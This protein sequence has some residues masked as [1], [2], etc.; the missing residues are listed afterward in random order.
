MSNKW[1]D[2]FN[3]EIL[4]DYVLINV[5]KIKFNKE[6]QRGI[7]PQ[8][9]KRVISSIK[10]YGY[11]PQEVITLNEKFEAIDG[12]HRVTAA[13]HCKLSSVP[14]SIIKFETKIDESKFFSQKNDWNNKL[15]PI[16]AW[17]AKYIAKH[18]TA[19]TVYRLEEDDNSL[20]FNYIAIKTKNTKT[21]F[22]VSDAVNIIST[23]ALD[24]LI[25]WKQAEDNKILNKIRNTEY[26]KIL[27]DTNN[28]L[29]IFYD[30]FGKRLDNP[31]AYRSKCISAFL[32]FY[33]KLK[34][35]D[36]LTT[37]KKIRDL[38]NKMKNFHIGDAY[39][40]TDHVGM[41]V[42]LIN[43]FNYK[44]SFKNQLRVE[45]ILPTYSWR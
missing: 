15:K 16:D 7:E 28:F 30:I 19:L 3:V 10:K 21:K 26:S 14:C 25:T 9:L 12:N 13:K 34:T 31:S 2:D 40:K 32:S 5:D 45:T 8:R 20:F 18:E 33:Y 23:C 35:N 17:H 24:Y 36:L 6:Y 38:K 43:H 22:N 1:E 11:M 27:Y 41:V 39:L 42:M 37:N 44:K 29:D 4:N